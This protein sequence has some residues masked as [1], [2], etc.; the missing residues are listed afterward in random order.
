LV[1]QVGVKTLIASSSGDQFSLRVL[2]PLLPY[3]MEA[4]FISFSYVFKKKQV[5]FSFLL[6]IINSYVDF[7]N[8]PHVCEL[9]KKKNRGMNVQ[10]PTTTKL[11]NHFY[12]L[13]LYLKDLAH[14]LNNMWWSVF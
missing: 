7:L 8:R 14:L 10:G 5:G 4:L 1:D 11:V 3:E 6:L 13:G 12:G 2:C 9:K